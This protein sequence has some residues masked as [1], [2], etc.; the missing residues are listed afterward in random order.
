MIPTFRCVAVLLLFWF[1]VSFSAGCGWY[2]VFSSPPVPEYRQPSDEGIQH[3]TS[4]MMGKA[5]SSTRCAS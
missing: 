1:L 4:R 2:Y 5:T 3:M